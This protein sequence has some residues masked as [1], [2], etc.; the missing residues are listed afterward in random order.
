MTQEDRDRLDR[1]EAM[2]AE[3][4]AELRRRP[5]RVRKTGPNPPERKPTPEELAAVD[6]ALARAGYS[7]G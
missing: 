4:L 7:R 5:K 3:V 1:I 6:V 2:L